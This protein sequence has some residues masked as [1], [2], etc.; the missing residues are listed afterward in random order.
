M[1]ENLGTA[2]TRTDGVIGPVLG[3]RLGLHRARQMA[4][5]GSP[6]NT[7]AIGSALSAQAVHRAFASTGPDDPPLSL[8]SP[9]R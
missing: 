3:A 2:T 4:R 6:R 7:D 1:R 9:I 8:S 5:R